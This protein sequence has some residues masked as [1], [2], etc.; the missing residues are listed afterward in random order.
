MK[1]HR[2]DNRLKSEILLKNHNPVFGGGG[3]QPIK[4]YKLYL[5]LLEDCCEQKKRGE[6][7]YEQTEFGEKNMFRNITI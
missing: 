2:Y 1:K 6:Y 3:S 4:W 7:T 5:S